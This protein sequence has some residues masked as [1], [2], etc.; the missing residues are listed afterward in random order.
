MIRVCVSGA[1]GNM[2]AL[3]VKAI[4]NDPNM[5]LSGAL[6]MSGSPNIG[7]DAG[8]FVGLNEVGIK[9]TDN[10]NEVLDTKPDVFV[11]FTIASAAE[12]NIPKVLDRS[13]NCIIGTTALSP[14]FV[15][16]FEETINKKGLKGM[17]SPNM[18]L[19]VNLFLKIA[20][21]LASKLNGY[22]IEIIEVHHH[23][24]KDSPSGTATKL[25]KIIADAI[26]KDLNSV[27]TW[28]RGKGMT[29]RKIGA[30]EIGVH[31]IRGGDIVGEHTVLYAGPGERIEFTH[32]AHSR[33]CFA[34]GTVEAIK[35][36][37]AQKEPGIYHMSDL[38]S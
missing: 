37:I 31:S 4:I 8:L 10:L 22:D 19:G 14:K 21:L 6:T 36:I 29:K 17:I 1:D 2:G 34:A 28:G 3:V 24:K 32:R 12:A 5:E 38:I 16:N 18:S 23:R 13:I 20:G 9:I 7:K 35:Y 30:E 26:G 33:E 11:D 25:A 15:K 27:V